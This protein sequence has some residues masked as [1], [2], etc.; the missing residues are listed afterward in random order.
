MKVLFVVSSNKGID[1]ISRR[2][3][4][5]LKE[6]GVNVIYYN[7][8]GKGTIGY[9]K[10]VL[11]LRKYIKEEKP[12]V[13]HA[14]YYLCGILATFTLTK[15]HVI[16]SLMGSDVL[17]A[18][19]LVLTLIRIFSKYFW[20]HTIAKSEEIKKKLAVR[21]STI[22]PNGV[23]LHFF[24]P[25]DKKL[26]QKQIGWNSDCFHILFAS[27]PDRPEKN[28]ALANESF[29][30]LKLAEPNVN[31]HFLENVGEEK[32]VH[33]FNAA[34]LLL[35]TSF[36]EGSPNVIKEAMAC[37]CPIVTTNVGDIQEVTKGTA[38]VI[39]VPYN[40]EKISGAMSVILKESKRSN[41]REFI[42]PLSSDLIAERIIEIYKEVIKIN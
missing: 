3:G 24:K 18:N 22:I 40:S 38:N 13:I 5:S 25:I 35:L 33:F 42:K 2:Q 29:I 21:N 34:D 27:S 16:V 36:Y 20:R 39:I 14:H 41:G 11:P 30:N 26:S 4:D 9:L 32:I 6:K 31:M 8:I 23:N 7:V 15:A 19:S 37:N 17:S 1:P 12:D 10:N 28:F